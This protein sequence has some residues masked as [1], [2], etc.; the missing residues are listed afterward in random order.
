MPK[1]VYLVM[2]GPIPSDVASNVLT[3]YECLKSVV[4]LL[5]RDYLKS[6]EQVTRDLKSDRKIYELNTPTGH[7]SI[8]PYTLKQRKNAL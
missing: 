5:E 3:S 2:V 7:Y 8:K 4:P 1:L 6:Y